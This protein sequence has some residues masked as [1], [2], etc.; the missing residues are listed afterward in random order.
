[1]ELIELRKEQ[2]AAFKHEMQEAFQKGYEDR[3]GKSEE[4][5]LPENDIMESLNHPTATAFEVVENGE[6]LGGAI[7]AFSDDGRHGDL[8][9]LYTK[10]G[11]QNRG[12]ATFAW[13]TI[14]SLYQEVEAWETHTPYFEMRNIHFYVNRC[15]FHIVE[16]FNSHHPD[17]N[18][19]N[20]RPVNPM[21]EDGFFRF[22]KI[23]S[24]V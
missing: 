11:C 8:H 2:V 12:V 1:M 18:D 19:F 7:I 21:G 4:R 3:F 22:E 20:E 6:R 16:F 15:G 9:F 5:I 14:E 24:G 10:V 23:T 17:P 13:N